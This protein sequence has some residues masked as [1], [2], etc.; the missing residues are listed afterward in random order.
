MSTVYGVNASPFVRKVRVVLEEKGIHYN[1]EPIVPINVP[2]DFKKLSPLGKIPAYR[3]GEVVL[4][5]SSVI[6]AYLE[7]VHPEPTLYPTDP[8]EYARALWF[9]EYADT[10]LAENLAA[11][12]FR[13]KV[14]APKL[15]NRPTDEGLV[16]E[17]LTNSIPPLFDYLESQL[18]AADRIV[19]NRFSIADIAIATQFVN[20]FHA[21]CEV[22]AKK[23]PKLATY[24]DKIV[25]RPVFK[26][27]IEE[28]RAWGM[29]S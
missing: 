22:D 7:R 3:D 1:I 23:W 27:L 10:A 9:E 19:G 18:E 20:F 25:S 15:M 21:G 12:V 6:C 13:E 5:D 8:Y 11:K 14:V 16:K 29:G 17:A 28:E 4:C 24:L 2:A 26:K